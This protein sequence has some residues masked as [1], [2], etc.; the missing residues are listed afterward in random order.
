MVDMN[1]LTESAADDIDTS[2]ASD[3]AE[4]VDTTRQA[5]EVGEDESR[6]AW[7][8]A[9]RELL[10]DA[11]RKYRA[12]VTQ[13]ELADGVQA[14][15]DIVTTQRMQQWLPDVLARVS[16][17]CA[18]RDEPNLA[19]LCV[20]ASGSVGEGYSA[21]LATAGDRPDD[22]DRHAA[23]VRLECYT[24]FGAPD[25]PAD[26]GLAALTPKLESSRARTKKAAVAARP[27]NM[28]PV[29][30]MSI[31]PNGTCVNCD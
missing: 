26:G 3:E 23:V 19:S 25:L 27:I 13:R 5:S 15:T 29:C 31:P 8:E 9:A 4:V 16:K 21:A 30:F 10:L 22:G 18:A 7:A 2:D 12:V 6:G 11:A 1:A 28:C 24:H 17:D 14:R 20:D